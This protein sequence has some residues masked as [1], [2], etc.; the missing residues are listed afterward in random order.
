MKYKFKHTFSVII[1]FALFAI[2][3]ACNDD[4]EVLKS[5]NYFST[6]F[7]IFDETGQNSV[8]LSLSSNDKSVIDLYSADNFDLVL[9]PQKD[10]YVVTEEDQSTLFAD[11]F[12]GEALKIAFGVIQE[13]FVE[14]CDNY[15]IVETQP[16]LSGLRAS[17][18]EKAFWTD[19]DGVRCKRNNMFRRVYITTKYCKNDCNSPNL[20]D[21][22]ENWATGFYGN[23]KIK[24]KQEYRDWVCGSRYM[25]VVVRSKDH[26]PST[27]A[28]GSFTPQQDICNKNPDEVSF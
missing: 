5:E 23:E 2:N 12:K 8:V 14:E 10:E 3:T 20:D 19:K 6:E 15:D 13:N 27:Y 21:I 17:F 9:N 1:V 7:E 24:N 18:S 28:Y 26:S 16:D 22:N 4:N 11:K 25:A